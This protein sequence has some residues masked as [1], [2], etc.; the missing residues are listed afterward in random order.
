MTTLLE[1]A[2]AEAAKLPEAEQEVLASRLLAELAAEDDFD[3]TIAGSAHRLVGLANEA[4]AEH[5][6]GLTEELDPE[7][8]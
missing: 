2:F 5:R 6:A 7:R 8:L 4:L 1:K 3:R